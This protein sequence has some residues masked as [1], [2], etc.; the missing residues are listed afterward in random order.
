MATLTVSIPK[1]LKKRMDEFPEVNWQ[2][3]IKIRLKKR[4]EKLEKFEQMR[5]QGDT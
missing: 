1:D 5:K 4:A 2:E 3:A